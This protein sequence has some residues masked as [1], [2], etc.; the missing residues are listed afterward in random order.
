[1]KIEECNPFHYSIGTRVRVDPFLK[2]LQPCQGDR[3]IDLGCGL[4]YFTNMIA[5]RGATCVGMD[6]D[7]ECIDY[8][9]KYMMGIYHLG[10]IT[11]IPYPDNSFNKVLCTE[12]L[13]HV[14]H[15]EKV[16]EEIKRVIEPGGILV[17]SV[18]C[19]E[20]VYKSL[21]K[22]IGHDSV[23]AGSREYHHHKGYTRGELTRLLESHGFSPGGEHEYTLIN[24]TEIFMGVTKYV[25]RQLRHNR[26]IDSQANALDINRSLLWRVYKQFFPFLHYYAK[27]EQK[28]QR[29]M[30]GHMLIVKAE[31]FK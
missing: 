18:P 1:M 14:E 9:S 24:T 30:K 29:V 11:D 26:K 16:L 4:G 25:V 17:V 21:F 31:C 13:E 6:L 3:V 23:D 10:D 15:N 7:G 22:R 28:L 2:M 27:V 5:S 8:C 20:G 12:V 19:S